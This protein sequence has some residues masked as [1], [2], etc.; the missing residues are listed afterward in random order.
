[1]TR[2]K[3][4]EDHEEKQARKEIRDQMTALRFQT[5]GQHQTDIPGH[6]SGDHSTKT[7]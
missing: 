2:Q 6:P 3:G 5:G 1:M 4:Q 7:K